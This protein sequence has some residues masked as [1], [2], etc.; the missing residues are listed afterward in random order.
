MVFAKVMMN[1][2]DVREGEAT[3][4]DREKASDSSQQ[5]GVSRKGAVVVAEK[6]LDEGVGTPAPPS[7]DRLSE[8]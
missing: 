3:D 5:R 2:G 1:G 7:S 6:G 4:C 8:R